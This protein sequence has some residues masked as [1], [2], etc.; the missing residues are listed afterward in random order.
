MI[1]D[2]ILRLLVK[3]KIILSFVPLCKFDNTSLM[4]YLNGIPNLALF[5]LSKIHIP[6]KYSYF[7]MYLIILSRFFLSF[8]RPILITLILLNL[9]IKNQIKTFASCITNPRC[10]NNSQRYRYS[11]YF[12]EQNMCFCILRCRLSF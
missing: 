1:S 2:N 5:G 12:T 11:H 8:S 6:S 3:Q 10:I 7:D 4:Q 9:L